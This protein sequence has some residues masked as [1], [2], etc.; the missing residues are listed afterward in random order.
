M[1]DI[2]ARKMFAS[3]RR[4]CRDDVLDVGGWDFFLTAK[5]RGIPFSTWTS[6]EYDET[7]V[8]EVNDDRYTLVHGDGCSMSF[9]DGRFDTVVN[10][11][12][13]EHV[14]EPLKMLQEI[15]RVLK[16]GGYAVFLIP[17]HQT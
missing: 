10:I 2:R 9:E 17:R 6:L 12:V 13:L 1:R 16:K 5:H 4:Y 14:L 11:H 8:L 15:A 7:R 3:L